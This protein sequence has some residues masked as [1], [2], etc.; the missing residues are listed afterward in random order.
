MRGSYES[1][2]MRGSG[3][4]DIA[5]LIAHKQRTDHARSLKI[6][7]V[8]DAHTVGE[9]IDYPDFGG[10][11]KGD[12]DRF[13]AY[14]NGSGQREC[15][16]GWARDGKNF[17]TAGGRVDGEEQRSIGGER[18]GTHL[19]GLEKGVGRIRVGRCARF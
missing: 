6:A 5:G 8:D 1:A 16:G 3:E 18:Q 12:G 17:E 7:D 4:N 19:S 9:V 13:Q 11:S 14:G 10:R 15:L 2:V